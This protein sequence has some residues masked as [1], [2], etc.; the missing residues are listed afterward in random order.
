MDH[1]TKLGFNF[2]IASI[3]D[4]AN[5]DEALHFFEALRLR[6]YRYLPPEASPVLYEALGAVVDRTRALLP[7]MER[8]E[9]PHRWQGWLRMLPRYLDHWKDETLRDRLYALR[10]AIAARVGCLL[11]RVEP[12]AI[13]FT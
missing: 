6:L 5:V 3:K 4:A 10:D 9:D 11:S 8:I 12:P 2:M 13:K 7:N 1:Q